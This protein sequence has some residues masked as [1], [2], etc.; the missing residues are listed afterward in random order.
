MLYWRNRVYILASVT[1]TKLAAALKFRALQFGSR[2]A[3]PP[4]CYSEFSGSN[5]MKLTRFLSVI[6][7][8]DKNHH[9][10]HMEAARTKV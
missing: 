2:K 10:V 7:Q 5:N 8:N 1:F 4:L 6:R 9:P 3:V